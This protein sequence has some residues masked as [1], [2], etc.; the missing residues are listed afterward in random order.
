MCIAPAR[1]CVCL[2]HSRCALYSSFRICTLLVFLAR[3]CVCARFRCCFPCD[4]ECVRFLVRTFI[5]APCASARSARRNRSKSF[6]SPSNSVRRHSLTLFCASLKLVRG[7]CLTLLSSIPFCRS[8]MRVCPRLHVWRP[9]ER[10]QFI[11]ARQFASFYA[12]SYGRHRSPI[13]SYSKTA[14]R[15]F[16]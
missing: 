11:Q 14:S 7:H 5:S 6:C 15:G 13:S 4:I 3:V 2:S 8:S 1:V 10:L 9:Q 12:H 16:Q